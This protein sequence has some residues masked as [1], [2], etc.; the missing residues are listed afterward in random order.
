[1]GV[2][3]V[4]GIIND[5]KIIAVNTIISELSVHQWW[6]LDTDSWWHV[7]ATHCWQSNDMSA[8]KSF[9]NSYHTRY[10]RNKQRKGREFVC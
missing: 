10:Q 8:S 6:Q 5:N 2:F 3:Y 7:N 9:P 4:F 1:M